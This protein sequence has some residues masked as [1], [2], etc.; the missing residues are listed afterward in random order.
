MSCFLTVDARNLNVLIEFFRNINLNSRSL[1]DV[2][3]FAKK[4]RNA[5]ASRRNL[6]SGK[7]RTIRVRDL[8]LEL[9]RRK[10]ETVIVSVPSRLPKEKK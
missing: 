3:Y 10:V 6:E 7:S 5:W 4:L 1:A 2:R 8:K 9:A